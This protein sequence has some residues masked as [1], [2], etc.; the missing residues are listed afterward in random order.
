MSGLAQIRALYEYNQ[1][2]NGHVL[3]AAGRVSEDD[4]RRKL[5]ASFDSV[6]G[7]L[8]HTLGAQVLWLARFTGGSQVRLPPLE[9]EGTLDSMRE[10]Y[11]DSHEGLREFVSLL[12]EDDVA[13]TLS[14]TDTRGQRHEPILWRCLLHV[15]NHGT[16]HRAET[17]LLLTSLGHPPRQLDYIFYEIERDGGAT[18]LT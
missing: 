9:P 15:A 4:L 12:S 3:D 6:L 2:A 5:G 10:T 11:R 17:A 14:Y 7:N 1:W 13:R 16:H 8:W 18:R